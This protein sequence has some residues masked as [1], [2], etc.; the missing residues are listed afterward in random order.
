MVSASA[1]AASS[2]PRN[3]S[4]STSTHGELQASRAHPSSPASPASQCALSFLRS[5]AAA[6]LLGHLLSSLLQLAEAEARR[7]A[8]GSRQLRLGCL[9]ALHGLVDKVGGVHVL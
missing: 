1:P 8:L 2:H 3:S 9:Q 4:S 7:G 6:P 5:E